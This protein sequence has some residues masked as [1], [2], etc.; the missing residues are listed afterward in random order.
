MSTVRSLVQSTLDNAVLSAGVH[1]FWQKK[2]EIKNDTNPD[3]Y[4]VYTFD[5]AENGVFADNEP[6]MKRK[7]IT[8]R[9]YCREEKIETE[10][11][12]A[13]VEGRIETILAA[14]K[15]AGFVTSTGAFDAGD[16]DDIGYMTTVIEFFYK[17]VV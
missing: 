16:I 15:A 13:A 14:M 11:G 17:R 2:N 6:L 1:S 8:L 5:G 12:R 10:A 7:D 3:E 9:Y 4:I